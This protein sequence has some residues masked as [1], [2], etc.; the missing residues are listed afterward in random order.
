MTIIVR[1]QRSGFGDYGCEPLG[2]YVARVKTGEDTH[3]RNADLIVAR[4]MSGLLA[5]FR[6]GSGSFAPFFASV[7]NLDLRADTS[8]ISD[9]ERTR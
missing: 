5:S 1:L 3:Q 4:N 9:M 2:Q 8:A 7:S 6:G